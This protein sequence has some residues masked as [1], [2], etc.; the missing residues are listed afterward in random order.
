MGRSVREHES[1]AS[2][3][4]DLR[5][6]RAFDN[7]AAQ[8]RPDDNDMSAHAFAC[9]HR[10][11]MN[12]MAWASAPDWAAAEWSVLLDDHEWVVLKV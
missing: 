7:D 3:V 8:C 2:T 12:A 10:A 4:H 6:A 1:K 11:L 9:Q 5:K